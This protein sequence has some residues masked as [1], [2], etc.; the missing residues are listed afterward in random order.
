MSLI[1]VTRPQTYIQDVL[2][3]S[4]YVSDFS[5]IGDGLKP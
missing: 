3:H 4:T 5:E 2:K 1:T